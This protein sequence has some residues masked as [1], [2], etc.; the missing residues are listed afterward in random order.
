MSFTPV[1]IQ[2]TTDL[3]KGFEGCRLVAYQDGGGKWTIGYGSTGPGISAGVKWSQQQADERLHSDVL[4]FMDRV[5]D[6]VKVPITDNQLAALTSFA[7]NLGAFNLAKSG[8]L[9]KLNH[10][11][12]Q[13]AADQFP[14]WVHI[15]MYVCPGLTKRRTE[16]RAIFLLP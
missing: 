2:K 12:Y 13:G 15:G 6:L 7:Y 4:A 3:I 9:K 10:Q 1:Q 8:L 14:L 16:E 11:D 5:K